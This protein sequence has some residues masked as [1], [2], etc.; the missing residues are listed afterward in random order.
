MV[1]QIEGWWSY[2][3][4]SWSNWWINFFKDLIDQGELST[5]QHTSNRMF[6]IFIFTAA[7]ER[8]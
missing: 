2:L 8:A 7:A 4:K 1:Q 5:F 6:V 3:R